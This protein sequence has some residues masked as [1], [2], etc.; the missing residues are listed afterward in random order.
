MSGMAVVRKILA[1][2]TAPV[3]R[4]AEMKGQMLVTPVAI[5]AARRVP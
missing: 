2:K 3:A 1:G 5:V 4:V